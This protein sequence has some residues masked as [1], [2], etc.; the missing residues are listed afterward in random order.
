MPDCDHIKLL[1]GP[2]DDG[3]LEPH[4]MEDV[5]LHIVECAEC[6]SILEDYRSL[7]VALRDIAPEPS[8]SGFAQAVQARIERIRPS[9]ITRIRR[10]IGTLAEGI[11]AAAAMGATAAAAAVLTAIVV[12]PYAQHLIRRQTPLN[13]AAATPQHSGPPPIEVASAPRPLP[14]VVPDSLPVDFG[15]ALAQAQGETTQNSQAMVSQLEADSPSVALW[16]EPQ[17]RTTVIWVPNQP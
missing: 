7:G 9:V 8:L 15:Q 10:H 16:N 1:L 11:G 13:I 2:F 17:T 6:K 5:A 3:E 4:E 12:T 14:S